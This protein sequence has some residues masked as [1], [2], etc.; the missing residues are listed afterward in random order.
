MESVYTWR[1]LDELAVAA[2]WVGDFSTSRRAYEAVLEQLERG[3]AVPEADAE[4]VRQNLSE[5]SA[6]IAPK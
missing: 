6:R 5:A 4:R 3:L 1:L 2:S